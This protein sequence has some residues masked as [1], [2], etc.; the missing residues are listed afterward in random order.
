M[1]FNINMQ[2]EEYKEKPPLQHLHDTHTHFVWRVFNGKTLIPWNEYKPKKKFRWNSGDYKE[3]MTPLS[4]RNNCSMEAELL[5]DSASKSPRSS[6]RMKISLKGSSKK[7]N[8]LKCGQQPLSST[9]KPKG[10]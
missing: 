8:V 3:N 10:M 6:I 9:V 1:M 5:E 7:K 4:D 2:V